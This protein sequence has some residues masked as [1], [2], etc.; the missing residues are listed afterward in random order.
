M[1]LSVL[2]LSGLVVLTH[3]HGWG[4]HRPMRERVIQ[5][6]SRA[7]VL[8]TSVQSL[9]PIPCD[10]SDMQGRLDAVEAVLRE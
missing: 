1:A 6:E 3:A 10:C 9:P 7:G 4:G 2:L 8:E 5:L